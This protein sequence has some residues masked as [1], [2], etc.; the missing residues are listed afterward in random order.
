MYMGSLNRLL[1]LARKTYGP[2]FIY[3]AEM[4]EDFVLMPAHEYLDDMHEHE[5]EL[6]EDWYDF[7]RR[8]MVED[9]SSDA[10]LDQI[11]RDIAAWRAHRELDELYARAD[12]LQDEL[13]IEEIDPFGGDMSASEDEWTTPASVLE[14][15]RPLDISFDIPPHES[16]VSHDALRG[17][18][19]P[20]GESLQW[21][22]DVWDEQ[23]P[24]DAHMSTVQPVRFESVPFDPPLDTSHQEFEPLPDSDAPV[25]Y[26]EP[27]V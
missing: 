2:V 20:E 22:E 6:L 27:I 19:P 15:Y 23:L 10:L 8:S 21:E 24:V 25:F 26:E 17:L 18:R 13:S 16:Y 5:D 9:M 1:N 14:S 7:E 11:N 12:L 4:E 3:D